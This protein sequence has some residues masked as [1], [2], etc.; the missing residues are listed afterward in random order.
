[1]WAL[2]E[3]NLPKWFVNQATIIEVDIDTEKLVKL[4]KDVARKGIGQ[5][6]VSIDDLEHIA[7]NRECLAYTL[8]LKH[9][10]E[11]KSSTKELLDGEESKEEVNPK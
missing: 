5:E 2:T 10:E 3:E 7:K 9:E 1:M 4:P 6:P 8:R 11:K